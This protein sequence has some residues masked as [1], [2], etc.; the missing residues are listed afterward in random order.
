[1]RDI[2]VRLIPLSCVKCQYAV[3]A[4]PD[5]VAWICEQCQQGLILDDARGLRPLDLFFSSALEPGKKGRPFWVAPGQVT[6]TQRQTYKGNEARAAEQFWGAQRLFYVPAWEA[7]LEEIVT[8]G[9]YL[10]RNPQGMQPGKPAQFLPAVTLPGDMQALCEFMIAS[11]EADRRDALKR[12]DFT[13]Q[14]QN[15]QMW[16]L[17]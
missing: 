3:P 9:V 14:L 2:P 15:P 17:P 12:I 10:L 1:M 4:Q 6:I 8:T 13:L 5:E 16:I 7:E 11:I